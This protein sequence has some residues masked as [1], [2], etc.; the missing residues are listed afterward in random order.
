DACYAALG[1]DEKNVPTRLV[2]DAKE[3]REKIRGNKLVITNK[4][5]FGIPQ[6]SPISALLSNIYMLPFDER[7]QQLAKKI[8][9]Y[10]RRYSDDILW[11][12]DEKHQTQVIAY[13]Q[14][15][16]KKMG[17]QL[18]INDKTT[19]TRFSRN[20]AGQLE[21]NGDRFQ[22]LGFEFDGNQRLVRSSTLS[23]FWRR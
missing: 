14:D 23:R 21:A 3:Y 11:I 20:T 17:A 1:I 4:N 5:T 16:I 12:C 13:V 6:G 2:R 15:E 9:G 19:V 22:Y 7:M 18:A 10:Y 8:G